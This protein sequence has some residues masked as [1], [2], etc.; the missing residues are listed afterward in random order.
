VIACGA[1]APTPSPTPTPTPSPTPTP[2]LTPSADVAKVVID[3]PSSLKSQS[4]YYNIKGPVWVFTI[5]FQEVNGIGAEITQKLMEIYATDG[6]VWGDRGFEDIVSNSQIVTIKIPPYGTG[7]YTSFV[8]STDCN[9]CGGTMKLEYQGKD[10]RGNP[11][12]VNVSF[13]LEK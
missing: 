2:T 10:D 11:V 7:S 12:E 1:P 13:V 8:N 9:L 5:E 6:S 3:F 4:S